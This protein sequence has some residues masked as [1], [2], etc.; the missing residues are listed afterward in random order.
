MLRLR[1]IATWR[2]EVLE[3]LGTVPGRPVVRAVAL[4]VIRNPFAGLPAV[5]T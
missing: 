1:K 4:A 3:E 2:E 5:K